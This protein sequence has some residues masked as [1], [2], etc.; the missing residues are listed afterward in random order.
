MAAAANSTLLKEQQSEPIDD[1]KPHKAGEQFKPLPHQREAIRDVLDG[2]ETHDR[3]QLSKE[4]VERLEKVLGWQWNAYPGV[5]DE[6]FDRLSEFVEREGHT[7][8][9][10]SYRAGDGPLLGTWMINQRKAFK[11]GQLSRELAERLEAVSG[12]QW[13]INDAAWNE[14]FDRLLASVDQEGH[15]QVPMSYRTGD[16]SRLG[17]WVG[18]QRRTF[19]AGK[20]SKEQVG[21]LEALLGWQWNGRGK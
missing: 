8:V 20:L 18:S 14:N 12:W 3:G 2:F 19:K 7:R 17:S 4:R 9:P 5:W 11:K 15:A 6:N 13:N 10:K 16:G 21:R 1:L